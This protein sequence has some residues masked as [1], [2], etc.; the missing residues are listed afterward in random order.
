MLQRGPNFATRGAASGY[1]TIQKP[2]VSE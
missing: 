1:N 2:S